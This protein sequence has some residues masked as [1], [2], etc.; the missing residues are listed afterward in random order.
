MEITLH[1]ELQ[2][3]LVT[4][5]NKFMEISAVHNDDDVQ[6]LAALMRQG[7]N[8]ISTVASL[9]KSVTAKLDAEK[10]RIMEQE[11]TITAPIVGAIDRAKTMTDAYLAERAKVA[12]EAKRKALE[13]ATMAQE[14]VERNQRAAEAFGITTVDVPTP[15]S[16]SLTLTPAEVSS[17]S[18]L[19]GISARVTWDFEITDANAIPREF[20]QAS[21]ALIKAYIQNAK[22]LGTAID[23]VRIPGVRVFEKTSSVIR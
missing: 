17:L 18:S 2:R 12:E 22:R 9:R 20:L 8:F 16:P 23:S 7:K 5:A 10:K 21:P 1:S 4:L 14:S 15:S 11:K 19:S 3:E 6:S 13:A